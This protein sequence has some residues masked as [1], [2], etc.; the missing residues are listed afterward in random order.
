MLSLCLLLGILDVAPGGALHLLPVEMFCIHP[1]RPFGKTFLLTGLTE[2]EFAPAE[3]FF[4]LFYKYHNGE[5]ENVILTLSLVRFSLIAA[6][7]AF[8]KGQERTLRLYYLVINRSISAGL[9]L[10]LSFLDR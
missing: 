5:F 10:S 4:L 7:H 9:N 6:I 2:P 3:F 1:A 8:L